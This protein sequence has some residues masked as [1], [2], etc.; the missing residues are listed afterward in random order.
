M[1]GAWQPDNKAKTEF[2]ELAVTGPNTGSISYADLEMSMRGGGMPRRRIV[3][4]EAYAVAVHVSGKVETDEDVFVREAAAE[5]DDAEDPADA[6]LAPTE[7]EVNAV[8]V[9][10]I[11]WIAPVIFM[12]REIGQEDEMLINWK[13]Q[14][15]A[16]VLNLLDYLADD[17]R[18]I[19]IRKRERSH[20]ILEKI[21][22]ATEEYRRESLDDVNQFVAD[23]SEQ[24]E[25]VRQEFADEI[26]ALE[27][28]TD[29]NERAKRQLVEITRRRLERTRDVKIAGLEKDRDRRVRQSERD[30]DLKIRGVQNRYKTYAVML[31]LI[32][33][34]LLAF[35]V[36]FNRRKAEREGVSATRLRYGAPIDERVTETTA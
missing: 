24:I 17:D 31:P 14:N 23:A 25:A 26:A 22:E 30:R 21:E 34:A 35:F 27:N 33:P 4:N 2:T 5:G 36:F 12:L 6:E 32:P 16:F 15:V 3:S 7:S 18:F 8:L 10:D 1:A 20:R 28:R 19:D 29:L 11:D 9:A 13:F